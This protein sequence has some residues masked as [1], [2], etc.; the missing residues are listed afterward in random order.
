[1]SSYCAPKYLSRNLNKMA[2]GGIDPLSMY[3]EVTEQLL[4]RL[5]DK[6]YPEHLK[7]FATEVI[8]LGDAKYSHIVHDAGENSWKQCNGVSCIYCEIY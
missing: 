3:T 4:A 1:M 5:A 6:L 8:G 2:C 7:R